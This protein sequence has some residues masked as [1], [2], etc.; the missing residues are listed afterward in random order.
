MVIEVVVTDQCAAVALERL[1]HCSHVCLDFTRQTNSTVS[2]SN[3]KTYHKLMGV[4]GDLEWL[5]INRGTV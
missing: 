2:V 1:L 4:K 5:L 3:H